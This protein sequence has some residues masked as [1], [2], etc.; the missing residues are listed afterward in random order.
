[1][2]SSCC[3]TVSYELKNINTVSQNSDKA[4]FEVTSCGIEN[5]TY[6]I[7]GHVASTIP[8][9]NKFNLATPLVFPEAELENTK[10]EWAKETVEFQ[11]KFTMKLTNGE[12]L[13]V[14]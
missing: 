8:G 9:I 4:F 7:T 10:L 2:R 5:G 12:A 1:M 3:L 14:F 6:N 11:G 13:A